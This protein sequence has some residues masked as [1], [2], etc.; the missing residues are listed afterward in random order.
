MSDYNTAIQDAV[1]RVAHIKAEYQAR[2][3]TTDGEA[4]ERLR[5]AANAAEWIEGAISM[6][7]RHEP[8]AAPAQDVVERAQK[9]IR[10]EI[11]RQYRDNERERC[12][13]GAFYYEEEIGP[14]SIALVLASAGLLPVQDGGWQDISTAPKD[15]TAVLVFFPDATEEFRQCSKI[16]TAF[17]IEFEDGEGGWKC[18]TESTNFIDVGAT[19]WQPLPAPPV[20]GGE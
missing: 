7:K 3:S 19:H 9:L 11:V 12:P 2:A 1:S 13:A 18:D 14:Y 8:D 15:G 20:Q 6:L 17:Y 16:F 4:A 10:E 5:T